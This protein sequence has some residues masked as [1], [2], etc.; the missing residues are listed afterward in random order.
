MVV[1]MQDRLTAFL[2]V[3]LVLAS[4]SLSM[5][6]AAVAEEAKSERVSEFTLANG[7]EYVDRALAAGI[8]LETFAPRL[9]FFFAA[10]NDVLEEVAKFRAARRLWANLM[11]ERYGAS[12]DACRLRFHTL[13]CR[14]SR[15][16]QTQR[17]RHR[18]HHLQSRCPGSRFR[19]FS[20]G[21][22]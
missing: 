16:L 2:R 14:R 13:C 19:G 7:L 22:G 8:P 17:Y 10:H 20:G 6:V 21:S 9:S 11:R 12:D 5:P 18:M 3:G 1:W 15:S 4:V